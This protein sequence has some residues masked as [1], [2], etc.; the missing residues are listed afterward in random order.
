MLS[1]PSKYADQMPF[2]NHWSG[3]IH[4]HDE[5]TPVDPQS[6][7]SWSSSSS[8]APAVPTCNQGSPGKETSVRQSVMGSL[9]KTKL[10]SINSLRNMKSP[11]KVKP[12]VTAASS[13][14]D[15]S[16]IKRPLRKDTDYVF[17][18][19]L[20]LQ[21]IS[22]SLPFFSTSKSHRRTCPYLT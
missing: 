22:P 15:V 21:S 8:A 3:A 18:R 7:D 2:S 9:R 6:P 13:V 16:V 4:N 12:S 20:T 19:V 11:T 5:N 10:R 1:V 14:T 17:F